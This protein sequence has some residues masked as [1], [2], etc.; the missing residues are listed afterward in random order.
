[1]LIS[2]PHYTV[3]ETKGGF[4]SPD[5][6]CKA[7]DASANG[8][9]RGEGVGVVILKRLS[10]AVAGGDRIY[11]VIRASGVNQDGRTQG[12]TVPKGEQQIRMMENVYREAGIE[13]EV[14]GYVEAHGTGTPI[15]DPIEANSLG[16][17]FSRNRPQEYPCIVGSVKTNMGHLE[18][19]AGIAGLIK[20][21][22]CLDKR[23]IPPHLHLV[24]PNPEIDFKALGLRVPTTLEP[25]PTYAEDTIAGVN[26]FGF[27]G[28]NAHCVLQAYVPAQHSHRVLP[29][30]RVTPARKALDP[31]VIPLSARTECLDRVAEGTYEWIRQESEKVPFS[32]F[33]YSL[34]RRR[35]HHEHRMGVVACDFA[36]LREKLQGYLAGETAETVV[37]GRTK[38]TDRPAKLCFVYTGNGPQWW[39]MGHE[40]YASEPVFKDAIDRVAEE[41]SRYAEWSLLEELFRDET[42]HRMG[43]TQIAQPANFAIQYALG[44]LYSAWGI[45]PDAVVG[46]STGEAGAFCKAGVLTLEEAVYVIY[47]RSRLQQSTTGM[48]TLLAVGLTHSQAEDLVTDYPGRVSVAGFNAPRAITLAGDNEAIAEIAQRLEQE[49]VF[50]KQ[51]RVNCPFH[52]PIM[53]NIREELLERLSDIRPHSATLPLYAAAT[54]MR[55][56]GSELG[57]DYW[58]HNV[59]DP[60]RFQTCFELALADGCTAFLEIGP[61]PVL[62]AAMKESANTLDQQVELL[63][64][65][66]RG[67]TEPEVIQCAVA[68]IYSAGLGPDFT[69]IH[70][71]GRLVDL[72]LYPFAQEVCWVEP[73]QNRAFRIGEDDH[74][75]LGRR[76]ATS[77]PIWEVEINGYWN[78]FLLDHRIQGHCLFPGAGYLEQAA[79]AV[80]QIT[81]GSHFAIEQIELHKALFLSQDSD[82]RVQIQLSVEE[83]SFA[84]TQIPRGETDPETTAI[85]A[86]GRF[87]QLQP[88]VYPPR[89]VLEELHARC[90]RTYSRSEL[91]TELTAMGFEYGPAFQG[92]AEVGLGEYESLARIEQ[93]ADV[94][95]DSPE[96]IFHPV[97]LDAAFQALIAVELMKPATEDR[98]IRLPVA[99]ER[100]VF[101]GP[102]QPT[103]W[104]HAR[105]V[106]RTEQE[107]VGEIAIYDHKGRL[108]ACV[109][110]FQ[111]RTV[112]Q[113]AG[114]ASRQTV[115]TWFYRVEWEEQALAGPRGQAAERETLLLFAPAGEEGTRLDE[116]FVTHGVDVVRVQQGEAFHYDDASGQGTVNLLRKSDYERLFSVLEAA[117][118]LPTRVV[119]AWATDMPEVEDLTSDLLDI[120]GP[121]LACSALY[122]CQTLTEHNA[123]ARLW[124]VTRGAQASDLDTRPVNVVQA[125][126]WGIGRVFGHQEHVGRWGGLIDLDRDGSASEKDALIDEILAASNEDQVMFRGPDARRSV[127]RIRRTERLYRTLPLRFRADGAYLITGAFGA[128]GELIAQWLADRGATFLILVAQTPLPPR[129]KW[130][131]ISPGDWNHRRIALVE[132]LERR[133][134]RVLSFAI[135]CSRTAQVSNL[136]SEFRTTEALPILGLFHCA[137][138]VKD[139]ILV[140]MQE[141]DLLQVIRPKIQ[142]AWNL[143]HLLREEPLEHFVLFSSVASL[144][145]STGQA[146]YA[147]DNA[148]LDALAH[149]RRQSGLPGLSINWGPWAIGMV[150]DLDLADHYR[151]RGM[152][153]IHPES[154]LLALETTLIQDSA[155][156]AITDAEWPTV[157][158]YYP[159]PPASFAHLA[160]E[161]D[162]ATSDVQIDPRQR[163]ATATG[164][165]RLAVVVDELI[166]LVARVLRI[167]KSAIEPGQTHQPLL[168]FECSEGLA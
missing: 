85:L 68:G 50:C 135:D 142:G 122:L 124:F 89:A 22:L 62:A 65:L 18:S 134:V 112:V 116:G 98:Q 6:R 4:L 30:M 125:P 31:L 94:T 40:L 44:E 131:Q 111:A 104:A 160:R 109:E 10:D 161:E 47:V 86:Q 107:T 74:P 24:K 14:V 28:T 140:Q 67:K 64:S 99:I 132:R 159:R 3:A 33:A 34:A 71:E 37:T 79:A 133:G 82:P 152:P 167:R 73:P 60:V 126:V 103:M 78:R 101:H 13:P 106:S 120:Q 12:I 17:F 45:E 29:S 38:P 100:V 87:R 153:P 46:H 66:Y 8:Y 25:W 2:T 20:A 148:F 144:V 75:L 55:A 158:E 95:V 42:D 141:Q 51:L 123:Q 83:G 137:G 114:G 96:W 16:H 5:G 7:F 105:V 59:R 70:P 58:W 151:K 36:D 23:Q 48:G 41:F 143:H 43:E 165:E 1:M 130:A 76:L 128:L 52:S 166:N 129:E 110:G 56:K 39:G 147:A 108:V 91:Y 117:G 163:I 168:L 57:A 69:R 21:T 149:Y 88:T 155:Q 164:E 81:A 11:A 54:G 113:E 145:T 127:M 92:V 139:S 61:H 119:Y 32:D 80:Y 84:I 63:H 121:A 90:P 118:K 138:V 35:T 19:A 157:L 102:A 26:S 136:L 162:T 15:G 154:G 49:G 9:A 93:P 72:S 77:S 27:G 146:N 156:I 97:V 53:E 150:R 115:A